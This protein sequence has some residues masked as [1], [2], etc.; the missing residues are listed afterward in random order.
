MTGQPAPSKLQTWLPAILLIFVQIMSGMRSLPQLAF[1]VIYLEEQIHLAPVTISS[2]VSG[3]QIAGMLTA[4]LGGAITGRMGSKWVMIWGVVLSGIGSL[5][6]QV[7]PLWGVTLLWFIGGAGLA[8]VTVGSSSYLTHVSTPGVIGLLAAFYALSTTAG[9]ALGNPLAGVLIEQYGF[10]PFSWAGVMTSVVTLVV[11]I[12]WM[13]DLQDRVTPAASPRSFSLVMLDTARQPAVRLAAG[14][15]C[16]PTIFYG[17]LTV[18]IPLLL[19]NLSGSKVLVAAYGATM[20]VVASGAQLLAGRAADRW[21]ARA[22]TLAFYGLM[23]LAG[24]G[25][26]LQA[27]TVWGL[28]V[29]GV[30]GNA[31]AWALATLMYVWISDGV[32]RQDHPATFGL[33]HAVWSVSM[34]AG[35]VLGGWFVTTLPGMV[36]LIAGMLNIGS[37]FLILA[38]YRRLG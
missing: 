29:F 14:L 2:V 8:L 16:L 21:G 3:A 5:A 28:F 20:L 25:L 1:F 23:I 27:G 18:L 38:Y 9:G 32:P 17:A 10:T 19:N 6:F 22:P 26:A 33:L 30:I 35:S 36:F 34:I 37:L 13:A 11:V 24:I 15:R 4:L 7:T 31:A 12:P